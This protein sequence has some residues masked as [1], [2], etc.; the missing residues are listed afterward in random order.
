MATLTEAIHHTS[1]DLLLSLSPR[2]AYLSER[3]DT[4]VPPPYDNKEPFLDMFEE[5]QDKPYAIRLAKSIVASWLQTEHIIRHG[6]LIVGTMRPRR[7]LQEFYFSGISVKDNLLA[8]MKKSE[9]GKRIL[10]RYENM[11]DYFHPKTNVIMQQEGIKRFGSKEQF[12]ATRAIFWPGHFQGHNVPDFGKLLKIGIGGVVAEI[13]SWQNR[14]LDAEKKSLLEACAIVYRGMSDWVCSYSK[15]AAEMTTKMCDSVWRSELKSIADCCAAIDW[16]PP[17]TLHQAAQLLWFYMLWDGPDSQGRVDQYLYPFFLDDLEAE[18]LTEE[19]AFDLIGALFLKFNRY[20]AHNV[21]LAGQTEDGCDASN[22]LT[23][24]CLEVARSLCLTMPRVT[25]RLCSKTPDWVLPKAIKMWSEGMGEPTI[26]NDEVVVDGLVKQGIP[27]SDARD[28][29]F[30]G[31]TEI[32]IC[33]KSNL[34]GEDADVN[35]AKCLELALNDGRCRLTGLQLGPKTGNPRG[36]KTFDEVMRAYTTQ[37][38]TMAK[39]CCEMSNIG[40]QIRSANLSKLVRMPLIADCLERGIDPDAG[41]A[42]YGH[43]EVMTLGIGITGDSLAAIKKLVFDEHKITMTELI[44]ALD[45]NFDGYESLH[46]RLIHQVPKYGNDDLIA[47][48]FAAEVAGHFWRELNKYLTNRG[49]AYLGGVIVFGRN[50]EFGRQTG[51]TPDGRISGA[52]LESSVG[53][54]SGMNLSGPTAMLRSAARIPQYLAPGGVLCNTKIPASLMQTAEQRHKIAD[55]IRTYFHL[56]GQQV[57]N[58]PVDSETLR[59]AQ[60]NPE[61]YRDLV[62]RVGGWSA[63]F[64]H[65]SRELQDDIVARAD[66]VI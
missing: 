45:A 1:Q 18:R 42:R 40:S 38:E 66:M 52:P 25:I 60:E 41:G 22:A 51:A 2:L 9:A 11:A 6:E 13:E 14:H 30:G 47:D 34:G 63:Y 27:V 37:V 49:G 39:H 16:Q 54:R 62:V 59:K 56:G 21:A 57:M 7:L 55:V 10:A 28:Y 61:E 3:Q 8:E 12:A 23:G 65:L 32:Q 50:I 48:K 29:A 15:K 26:F 58:T 43:G 4:D 24:L 35:L 44:N 36:F 53:P 17:K 46:Q 20:P 19:E 5:Y 31:C 33:G 64:V